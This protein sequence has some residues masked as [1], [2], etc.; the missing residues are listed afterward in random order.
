MTTSISRFGSRTRAFQ[1][2]Y[3]LVSFRW[4]RSNRDSSGQQ[5]CQ[6]GANDPKVLNC[7]KLKMIRLQK[8]DRSEWNEMLASCPE[9]IVKAER[10]TIYSSIDDLQK[11]QHES[12]QMFEHAAQKDGKRGRR[13]GW[14]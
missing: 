1:L 4:S 3:G 13:R 9:A 7:E 10:D 8:S 12:A 2:P 11:L 5:G 14:K 6:M